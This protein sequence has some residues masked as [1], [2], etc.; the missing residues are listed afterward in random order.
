MERSFVNT[1]KSDSR[2]FFKL[3]NPFDALNIM[4]IFKSWRMTSA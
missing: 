2:S 4:L 1:T 3:V